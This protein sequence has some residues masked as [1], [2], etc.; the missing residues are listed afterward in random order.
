MDMRRIQAAVQDGKIQGHKIVQ[1]TGEIV[2]DG[3]IGMTLRQFARAV[4]QGGIVEVS[5][6]ET[7]QPAP[8]QEKH[9]VRGKKG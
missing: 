6:P 2:F 9:S 3:R 5:A 8:V 1:S 7:V 4:L